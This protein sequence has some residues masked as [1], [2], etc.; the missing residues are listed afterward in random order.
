MSEQVDK[1]GV[2]SEND[3]KYVLRLFIIGASPNSVSAITNLKHLC[4]T[5]IP[6][7][8]RLDIIDVYQQPEL[9]QPEQ[10]VA[11]PMLVKQ[12]PLPEQRLIGDM[13]DT[14]RV[15]AGLGLTEQDYQ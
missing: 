8:Y 7:Q 1:H 5:Y 2:V 6:G 9:A 13:S 4:E 3:K 12:W 11:L 15:L 10:L 14:K